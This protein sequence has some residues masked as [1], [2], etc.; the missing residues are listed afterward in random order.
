MKR[1]KN[2]KNNFVV[3]VSFV[4]FVV[5]KVSCFSFLS[6]LNLC[7]FVAKKIIVFN[8]FIFSYY[9]F[10]KMLTSLFVLVTL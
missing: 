4:L 3:F 9:S 7:A 6:W 2:M 5:H 8:I 1:T 10:E